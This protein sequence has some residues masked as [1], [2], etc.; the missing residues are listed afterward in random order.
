MAVTDGGYA[1]QCALQPRAV[2][3]VKITNVGDYMVNVI[4]L[5]IALVQRQLVINEAR[6][7]W[8]SE[9]QDDLKQVIAV[10]GFFQSA[11]DVLW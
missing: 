9:V 1:V 5:Y 11:N 7:W 6:H 10:V 2:I 3:S 4:A 8:A